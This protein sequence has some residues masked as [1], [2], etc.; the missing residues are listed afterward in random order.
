[1]FLF[2]AWKA[3]P[4]IFPGLIGKYR[5]LV[6]EIARLGRN[7]NATTDDVQRGRGVLS[8][9]FG[10]IRV[11]PR[12]DVLVA[13]VTAVGAGLLSCRPASLNTSFVVAWLA[14]VV[15]CKR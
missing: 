8:G 12:G 13:K 1:M 3:L 7:P 6:D 14:L 11:E 10:Q 2:K 4:D 9:L 15:F 5:Q